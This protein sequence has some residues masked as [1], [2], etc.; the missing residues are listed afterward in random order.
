MYLKLCIKDKF[1][2]L[3]NWKQY[4][5]EMNFGRPVNNTWNK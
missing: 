1:I 2:T 4:S 5:I 3:S